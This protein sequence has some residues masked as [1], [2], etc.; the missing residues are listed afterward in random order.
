MNEN[1][2]AKLSASDVAALLTERAALVEK[3]TELTRQLDWFKRQLFGQKSEKLR[4]LS[5]PSLQLTLG[6][7]FAPAQEVT[8]EATV[9]VAGHARVVAKKREV[10]GSRDD[11]G[12]R[13]DESV[14]VEE[15]RLSV[16]EIEGLGPDK[17]EVISEVPT[18]RLAQRPSSYYVIKFVR[19]VVKLKDSKEIVSTP[20][21]HAVFEKSYADVTFLAGLF[22]DKLVYH[23]P[24]HRQHQRLISAGITVSRTTLTNLFLRAA[25]LLSPVYEAQYASVLRSLVLSMDETP[26]RAGRNERGKMELCQFW[27]I[28]GDKNEVVFPFA[29]TKGADVVKEFLGSSFQGVLLTDGNPSYA[30]YAK[31]RMGVV[32]ACCWAHTRREF[33]DA[34]AA[35][36]DLCDEALRRIGQFY[37]HEAAIRAKSLAGIAKL[38]YR[39]E[40]VAPLV[41]DF[42]SWLEKVVSTRVLLPTDLFLKAA[43]YALS[44]KEQLKVF[45]WNPEVAIDTNHLERTLRVIPMGRKNYLFCWT[46][47]GAKAVGMMQSLLVTSRLQGVDP[48]VYLVDVL[49]RIDSH[50][51]SEVALLTPRLWKEHFAMDPIPSPLERHRREMAPS[52]AVQKTEDLAA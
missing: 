16:P 41:E 15:V 29:T 36:P 44:R 40:H 13:F 19:P 25:R 10:E 3:V 35:V 27:P 9:P 8:P 28:Y 4:T 50:P 22:I 33:F 47:V 32:Q 46:E 49:Q 7:A 24:L 1:E 21:P 12:L 11:T 23:L 42:F 17:Y 14:P 30:S 52:S 2:A 5:S 26:I 38:H 34:R 37:E 20:A 51:A 6:E 45:L 48:F 39:R 18:Y 43:A 31:D